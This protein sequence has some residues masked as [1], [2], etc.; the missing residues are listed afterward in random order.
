MKNL[1]LALMLAA[2]SS[3]VQA[4]GDYSTDDGYTAHEWGTFTSIQGTDGIPIL[5]Q[6]LN[7]G[8]LPLFVYNRTRA[9]D[10]ALLGVSSVLG[11]GKGAMSAIQRMETPVIYFYSLKLQKVDVRVDFPEG[12]ITE[13]YPQISKL[14]PAYGTNITAFIDPKQRAK[15]F[16]EWS[17]VQVTPGSQHELRTEAAASHYYAAR[18]TDAAE[19]V[20]QPP[21]VGIP[22][23]SLSNVPKA[24]NEKF[25]FYRGL[26]NFASPL[27]ARA[28]T[29]NS[30]LIEN[31][32][33]TPLQ[34]VFVIDQRQGK[35]A[36]SYHAKLNEKQSMTVPTSIRS[37]QIPIIESRVELLQAMRKSLASA[38]LFEKEAA[39]MVKTWE[40]S[41]F[42]EPGLRVLYVLPGNWVDSTLPLKI[43]PA[44]TQSARVFVGR[45]ELLAPAME[46][47]LQNLT[48]LYSMADD[49][50]RQAL[51]LEVKK[52]R[53]GRFTQAAF[54]RITQG[55]S[56]QKF[57][58]S[59]WSLYQNSLTVKEPQK[60]IAQA[61]IDALLLDC[62]SVVTK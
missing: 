1:L 35:Y 30:V 50:Q 18:E 24:Q 45:A 13:W 16:I 12:N 53:L 43:T 59:A 51:A 21:M 38:G 14:G 31:V 40:D 58:N 25:L 56:D 26:G 33:D 52:F 29:D 28:T 41:W 6:S 61:E 48:H 49:D 55:N 54:S 60:P 39:A 4:C 17:Q 47:N 37:S 20:V 9:Q 62:K 8:D 34:H 23:A 44:P 36:F 15:S 42:D 2:S 32:M 11:G 27:K 46:K 10:A 19:I 5:W 3:I 22:L 57:V 7:S